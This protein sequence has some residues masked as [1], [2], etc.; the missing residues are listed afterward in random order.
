MALTE[1]SERKEK[2]INLKYKIRM[3]VDIDGEIDGQQPL[4]EDTSIYSFMQ[5]AVEDIESQLKCTCDII[6]VKKIE[7]EELNNERK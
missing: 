3:V 1:N 4:K 7:L 6:D 5:W 2:V